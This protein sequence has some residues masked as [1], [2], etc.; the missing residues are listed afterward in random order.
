VKELNRKGTLRD[1]I[2]LPSEGVKRPGKKML[3][4]SGMCINIRR[5]K[6]T[7]NQTEHMLLRSD[8]NPIYRKNPEAMVHQLSTALA[9]FFSVVDKTFSEEEKREFWLQN[10]GLAILTAI[11]ECILRRIK[12]VPSM[13]DLSLYVR[14]LARSFREEQDG[15]NLLGNLSK[16]LPRPSAIATSLFQAWYPILR[17]ELFLLSESLRDTLSADFQAHPTTG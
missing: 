12:T 7:Q 6:L 5:R 16:G 1:R 9:D 15:R 4:F 3:K 13:Q 8:R 10:S 14:A 2:Y 11:Y 17:R